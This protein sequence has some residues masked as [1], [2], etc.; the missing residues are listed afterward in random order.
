MK[1]EIN[2]TKIRQD[3][4]ELFRKGDFYCSEAIVYSIKNNLEINMPDEM[5]AMASGFPVGIGKSKC[6]CGAVSGGI[7]S[8]GYFFG[9]T[10]GGDPK[11]AKTLELANELQESFK[12]NHKVLCCKILTKGMDMA[13]GEHKTQC[14]SF[15]GEIAQKS[16]EIIARELEL[17]MIK[18]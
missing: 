8:L 10:K 17:T 1:K 7:L 14:I 2:I 9:R 18:E 15:T 12:N 5:V 3:A 6:V 16:A 4:E 11:V 13:S